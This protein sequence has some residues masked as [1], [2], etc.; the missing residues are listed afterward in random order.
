MGHNDAGA[1]VDTDDAS[2]YTLELSLKS[3]PSSKAVTMRCEL[4]YPYFE[5]KFSDGSENMNKNGLKRP[6]SFII[7]SKSEVSFPS[8]IVRSETTQC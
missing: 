4:S 6:T 8:V 2:S 3:G 7:S 1:A 5:A